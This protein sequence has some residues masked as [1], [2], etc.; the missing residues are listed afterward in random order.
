MNLLHFTNEIWCN[1]F[2]YLTCLAYQWIIG[3]DWIRNLQNSSIHYQNHLNS[4]FI[5]R[6]FAHNFNYDAHFITFIIFL[7]FRKNFRVW[8]TRLNRDFYCVLQVCVWVCVF[9]YAYALLLHCVLKT[10]F[11]LSSF[12]LINHFVSPHIICILQFIIHLQLF[13]STDSFVQ[14]THLASLIIFIISQ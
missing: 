12:A 3:I 13:F 1:F 7:F 5:F 6:H 4:R 2:Y 10:V 11:F 9:L 8:L 14:F